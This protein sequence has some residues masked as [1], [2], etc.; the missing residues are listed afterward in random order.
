[1]KKIKVLL[2]GESWLSTGSHQKGFDH[3]STGIYETGHEYL[4]RA[5][6]NSGYI[7]CTHMP[8]HLASESFPETFEELRKYD[9]VILSDIG[10]N[11]LLLSKKVFVEGKTAPNRLRLIKEWVEQGG[12][13]C[14]CGGYLSF[15]GIQ[16]L[17][18]Y[19]RTPI[20]EILPVSIH[21]FDDRFE[22]PEGTRTTV[23]EYDHPIVQGVQGTWPPLLGYQEAV[24]KEGA[25]L[26][27]KSQYGHPLLASWE[28]GKGRT[29]AWM[30]DIGPHWCPKAFVEWDGYQKIWQQAMLWLAKGN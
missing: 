14:M 21:T 29:F 5:F 23:L 11:T 17:A 28:Y 3:F 2:V 24:M 22:T 15:A 6:D 10:S 27:A 19:F 30:T 12:G 20:E 16:G 25:T 26:I 1:M 13:F 9:V 7:E 18:K 8:S 4:L